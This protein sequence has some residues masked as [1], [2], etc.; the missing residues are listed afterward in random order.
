MAAAKPKTAKICLGCPNPIP[1]DGKRRKYCSHQCMYVGTINGIKAK[2]AKGK[3]P[4]VTRR[5]KTEGC[6][7]EF[8]TNLPGKKYCGPMCAA[9]DRQKSPGGK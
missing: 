5:C 4:F 6:T 2:R 8:T 7:V 3:A 9:I 1:A